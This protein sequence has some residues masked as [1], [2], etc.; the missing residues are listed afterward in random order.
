MSKREETTG[1]L[2][3][4]SERGEKIIS[5]SE[6]SQIKNSVG[7]RIVE[8]FNYHPDSEIAFLLKTNSK[9]VKSFTEGEELPATQILLSIH[10]ITGVSIHWLL[11]GE[12]TKRAV[13]ET[14]Y[15]VPEGEVILSGLA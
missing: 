13:H 6:M 11:T 2:C 15:M 9:T 4:T 1:P 5:V 14:P 8:A 3:M 12:G 7:R 10:K